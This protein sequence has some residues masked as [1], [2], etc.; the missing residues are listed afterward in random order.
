MVRVEVKLTQAGQKALR[1]QE[2]PNRWVERAMP[3]ITNLVARR[4]ERIAKKKAPV[5]TGGGRRSIGTVRATDGHNIVSD[6]HMLVMDQGRRPG[7]AMPPVAPL[8]RWGKRVL[9]ERNLGFVLARSIARKG[10]KPRKFFTAAIKQVT[11]TDAQKTNKEIGTIVR[12]EMKR[13]G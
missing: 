6:L 9:G 3:Q 8:E 5:R 12:R 13:G 7:A 4:I 10:I 1:A 2:K 11:E